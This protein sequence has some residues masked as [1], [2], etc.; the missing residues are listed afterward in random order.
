MSTARRSV[1]PLVLAGIIGLALIIGARIL[2]GGGGSSGDDDPISLGGGSDRSDCLPVNVVASSEK[3]ALLSELAD[4]YNGTGPSVNG[5]CVDMTVVSKASGG[6]AQAL[7]RGWDEVID[8]PRPDVWTP[9][10]SSWAVL[11]NQVS[12]EQDNP[13]PIPDD[14]PSLV[15]TPLVIAMPKPMAE[16]LGW[17]KQQIGWSDLVD[18]AKSTEGWGAAGHPEWASSNSVR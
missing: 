8:G 5:Q 16:A 14:L 3:A 1:L 11:V 13:S 10:S 17:P 15:Q 9:A 7:A 4:S 18:L 6:A 2:L 12:A